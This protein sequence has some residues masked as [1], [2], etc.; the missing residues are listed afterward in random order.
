M[1]EEKKGGTPDDMLYKPGEN[2]PEVY[3]VFDPRGE[4]QGFIANSAISVKKGDQFGYMMEFAGDL[5]EVEQMKHTAV[6][7]GVDEDES[8][9]AFKQ[10]GYEVVRATEEDFDELYREM[11]KL[12][13]IKGGEQKKYN[14]KDY[15]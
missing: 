10:H 12:K 5:G 9:S 4:Y 3:F 2:I 13:T 14:K 7:K 8:R 11:D 1:V 15:E 6:V